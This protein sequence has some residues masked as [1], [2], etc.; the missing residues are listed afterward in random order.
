MLGGPVI[1]SLKGTPMKTPCMVLASA[2]VLLFA[3]CASSAANFNR[4]TSGMNR[5]EVVALLGRPDGTRVRGNSEYLTYYFTMDRDTGEQPYLV[6]LVDD[7]VDRV[8][9]F[10]QLDEL[11]H[12]GAPNPAVG[13]GAILT[14]KTFPDV[15][16]QL[17]SLAARRDKGEI[18]AA[19][20]EQNR[21]ELLANR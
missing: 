4:V 19:E 8:G 18:S 10:V 6:R 16:T 20:F 11:E 15:A 3:G 21:Q 9:R 7:Q 5:S 13:M 12:I 14:T 17:R 1:P 2:L